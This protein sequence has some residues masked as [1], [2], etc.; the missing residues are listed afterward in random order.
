MIQVVSDVI[1]DFILLFSFWFQRFFGGSTALSKNYLIPGFAIG[2]A[3]AVI[4][5]AIKIIKKVVW[6]N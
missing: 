2:I 3:I 6:G 1:H 5:L 4:F